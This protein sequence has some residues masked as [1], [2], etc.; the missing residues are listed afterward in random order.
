MKLMGLDDAA[1]YLQTATGLLDLDRQWVRTQIDSGKLPCVV[2]NRKR[3]V[4]QT[5]L[6]RLCEKWRKEAA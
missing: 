5:A 3:R 2:I 6:D 4:S 1:V